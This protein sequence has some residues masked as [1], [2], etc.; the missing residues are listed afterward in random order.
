M[1][2]PQS[3]YRFRP[4]AF[5]IIVRLYDPNLRVQASSRDSDPQLA[6]GGQ[7]T[8]QYGSEFTIVVP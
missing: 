4:T 2:A 8:D 3:D 1:K 5:R 7:P 6:P